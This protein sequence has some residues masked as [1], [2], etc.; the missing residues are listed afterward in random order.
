MD[1]AYFAFN[2]SSFMV[3]SANYCYMREK[4][5]KVFKIDH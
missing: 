3:K 5:I 1:T 4:S 2:I